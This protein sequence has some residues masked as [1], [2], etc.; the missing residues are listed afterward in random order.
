MAKKLEKDYAAIARKRMVR[1]AEVESKPRFLI[2][3]RNKKG[4]T[5]FSLSAGVDK[6]LVLDPEQGTKEM[7]T[8]NPHVW[9][10][11]RWEDIDDAYEFL[12]HVNECTMPNCDKAPHPFEWVSVDGLTKM[13]NMSLKY[14]MKLEEERSLTRI[15]GMVQQ[16]DYGKSG[17]LMKDMLV[18]FHNLPL[19]IVFTAQERQVEAYDSEE[20]ED[21]EDAGASYVPDLPKG[22]RG[23]AN[24]IVDVIGRLYV[25]KTEDDPP[26]AER[27]LWVGESARYDTGYRSDFVLPDIVRKPTIP[28]LVTLMRTGALPTAKKTANKNK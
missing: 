28:R 22:V 2:Y 16:R 9:P 5:T 12:R 26:R 17:E 24:S 13:S 15:P 1:P 3:S 10:I 4:K 19:G 25:V 7:K 6:T 14:V 23:A 20:D 18:R 8:K 27:R 21:Y 11:D